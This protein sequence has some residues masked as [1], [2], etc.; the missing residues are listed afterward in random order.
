LKAH[1][2]KS[3]HGNLRE[4]GCTQWNAN[5]LLL[6]NDVCVGGWQPAILVQFTT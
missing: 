3:F 5:R 4:D 1:H 6:A 2:R